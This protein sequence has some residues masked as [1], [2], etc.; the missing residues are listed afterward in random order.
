[1]RP[2][3]DPEVPPDCLADVADGGLVGI[4]VTELVD[5][6]AVEHNEHAEREEDRVYRNWTPEEVCDEIDAIVRKKDCRAFGGG[7][8]AKRVLVIATG[9]LVIASPDFDLDRVRSKT[10]SITQQ[11]DQAYLLLS[12]VPNPAA[13]EGSYPYVRLPVVK[14]TNLTSG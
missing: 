8:Y 4:E 9:E 12:Y 14:Q 1:M 11:I 6:D 13:G 5:Q 7:P 3:N 10:P 2:F